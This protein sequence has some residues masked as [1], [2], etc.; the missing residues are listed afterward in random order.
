MLV[1]IPGPPF[2]VLVVWEAPDEVSKTP[3]REALRATPPRG[4]TIPPPA[5]W[6]CGAAGGGLYQVSMSRACSWPA[7]RP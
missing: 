5:T 2:R 3:F 6:P 1:E 4:F 7:V